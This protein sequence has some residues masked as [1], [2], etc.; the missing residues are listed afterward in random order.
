MKYSVEVKNRRLQVVNDAIGYDGLL[1]IGTAGMGKV[2]STVKLSTPAFEK[3]VDGE[4][5][6]AGS[7]NFDPFASATGKARAAQ[8]TTASGQVVIDDLSVGKSGAT[9]ILSADDIVE[10]Q[11]VRITSGTIIHA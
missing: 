1:R 10:G 11:E 9:I 7:T 4:M 2:L 6:L 3:P 8:I 5:S